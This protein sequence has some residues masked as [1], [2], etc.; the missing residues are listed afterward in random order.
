MSTTYPGT[1]NA[2]A[3]CAFGAITAEYVVAPE[4]DDA[5][6]IASRTAFGGRASAAASG[7]PHADIRIG[8]ATKR[9]GNRR[10]PRNVIGPYPWPFQNPLEPLRDPSTPACSAG[11]RPRD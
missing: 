4:S 7:P 5:S 3:T 9:S 8:A 11:S 10:Q 1:R 6:T 2:S